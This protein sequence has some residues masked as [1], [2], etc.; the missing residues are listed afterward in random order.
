MN[1]RPLYKID[2]ANSALFSPVVAKEKQIVAAGGR[3]G[4]NWHLWWVSIPEATHVAARL[5]LRD[6]AGNEIKT[7]RQDR[8][9]IGVNTLQLRFRSGDNALVD[10]LVN[11]Q[12]Y[13]ERQQD[14]VGSMEVDERWSVDGQAVYVSA[15]PPLV[16]FDKALRNKQESLVWLIESTNAANP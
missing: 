10:S 9:H 6:A 5:I 4:Q 16:F 8:L 11:D 7:L 2:I 12:K 15:N 13:K 1:G 3:R 14:K